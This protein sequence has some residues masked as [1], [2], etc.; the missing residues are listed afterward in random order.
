VLAARVRA[1]L[2][3]RA[4]LEYDRV[5]YA[6]LKGKGAPAPLPRLVLPREDIPTD[7]RGPF[8]PSSVQ[9]DRNRDW[10]GAG[11]GAGPRTRHKDGVGSD[12]RPA[13]YAGP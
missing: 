7:E 1:K 5:P 6:I 8:L 10:P 4:Q 13:R 2:Q 12:F 9:T 11:S 3:L